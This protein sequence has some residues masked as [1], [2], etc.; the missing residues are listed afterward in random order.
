MNL[1]ITPWRLESS[2]ADLP[3]ELFTLTSPASFPSPQIV[4]YNEVLA[5]QLGLNTSHEDNLAPTELA[6]YLVGNKYVSGS[7]PLAQAYAGFQFGHFSIL[8]D[9]RAVLLG[10]Y[11]TLTNRV[12]DL[13]LKGSG[14]TAYSRRGDGKATL[15]SMLREYLMSEAMYALG[16]PTTRSLSVCST[17]EHIYRGEMEQGAVLLRV[18]QSHIRVGTIQYA[19]VKGID[20]LRAVAD[21]S[22][23]RHY[24]Y[25]YA[26]TTPSTPETYM[27]LL[28]EVIERQARLIAH[29]MLLGFVHG[30]MN[31]DNMSLSGETI[32]YGPCAFVDNYTPEACFSS[33]DR[34]GR[35]KL[36][37]QPSIGLWNLS[38][39]A[40]ALLPLLADD[41]TTAIAIAE[42]ELAQYTNIYEEEWLHGM[43]HK[44]GL[45]IHHSE[46]LALIKELLQL[47]QTHRADYTN[48]FIRLTLS[49]GSAEPNEFQGT[50]EL[51]QA[52]Q[53]ALWL[54]RYQTRLALENKTNEAI[55]AQMQ[56]ANPYI[57]PRNYW[58]E[59]A[60]SRANQGD[61]SLMEQLLYALQTPY[62]YTAKVAEYQSYP[63]QEMHGYQT[64]CGT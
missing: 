51:W 64:Y 2:Y 63:E 50:N 29:W 7:K 16:I 53:F 54:E 15:S 24:P 46:D 30:V 28:R 57:I 6:Q 38:R 60:L 5:S 47:L 10:E 40:E 36:G 23:K 58:V 33:I 22:I 49:I 62:D 14:Q 19:H 11:R 12:Y 44:L 61:K 27:L 20:N 39:F 42:Q 41:E 34:D 21:Y 31:T 13:Q 45:S 17:G 1:D 4:M 9:G 52:E 3:E 43:R 26:D 56:T 37:N 18:A 35:Y 32:D 48:T 59:Q 8:G 55:Q 25:I